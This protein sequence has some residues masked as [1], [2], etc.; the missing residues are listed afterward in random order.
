M[1]RIPCFLLGSFL[2]IQAQQEPP[3]AGIVEE[4]L[5][6]DPGNDLFIRGKNIYDAAQKVDDAETRRGEYLRAVGIF[7]DY[8][9]EF[10]R[11]ANAEA[12]WWYLGSSYNQVGM[13]DDARR[14]F[15]TLLNGFGEGKYA[16]VAAYSMALDHYNQREY[17]FAAPLFEKFAANGSR[18]EDKPTGRLMAGNC[19]RLEGRER[20]A[21]KAFQEV[22]D[23][24]K[25]A[26]L[27]D[28][29]RLYLGHVSFKQGKI[30]EALKLFEQVAKSEAPEKVRAE[31]ALHAAISATK[32]GK[33]EVAETY[34]RIV[35]EK[36]GMETARPD[37]QIA[38]MENYYTAKKYKEVLDVYKKSTVKAEGPKEAARLMIAARAMLQLK[39][40]SEASKLFR[41]IERAVPPEHDLA[42]QAS[43]YRLN[44]FF[45][46]KGEYVTEQ[47][48][49]FLQIYE[50]KRPNDTRIH[51]ALLIKAETLFSQNKIPAAA[52]IYAKIDPKLLSE[53]N[54]AGFLYQRG[55]C[56]AEAGDK[57]GSIQ[58]LSEFITQYPKDERVHHA[59]VKRAKSYVEI[60]EGGK[61]MA[62]YDL[63]TAAKT[64]PADLVSLAWLESARARR[65]EGNIENMLV[66]YKGLLE[67]KD[68]SENLRSEANYWIG[69]GMVK[70]NQPKDAVPFL[71]EARKLRKDAYGKHA[72]LLLALSH[73]AS[74][75]PIQLAAEIELA[76]EGNYASE[77]PA[78]ALQWTGMQSYNAKNYT[79]AAKFLSLTANDKEPRTTPKEVWRYLG[80]SRLEI[81]QTK[82]A[83]IAIG[84][85]LE[86]EDQAAWKADGLLDRARGHYQLKQ[87]D[88]AR[89][90]A[91]EG[92]VLNPQGRTS[93]GL[94][95]V[96]GDLHAQKEN[97]G[98]AAADYLYVI[99]FSQDADLKPLAIHKYILLLEKQNKE[100]EAEKYKTQLKTEFPDWKAP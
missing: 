96:S 45:Q 47:V 63:V 73:F 82:E 43:Y 91:D 100:D 85:V 46:I 74:Q 33:S 22:I 83:L 17:A 79:S 97:I 19:Y 7:N 26:A 51:T 8:L 28:Q 2:I 34:L 58:S 42:F 14:C 67:V 15:S 64:A 77:I 69:W 52:E 50:K 41:E 56:L 37:A 94:R 90:A 44:C 12:A 10:G 29:A 95:I 39:E 53:S 59:L 11:H 92:L 78:Q 84:H 98:A 13:N 20:D 89:K 9:N 48:D 16:G 70:T 88:E 57:Q 76:I 35:L 87:F 60:G 40:V 65:K 32:L 62:D 36:P 27:H 1:L 66:R 93:A 30:D 86:V 71:K 99:Q 80:K 4:A 49:A 6:V 23:D 38:L 81:N 54:R 61:A 21:I 68:L 3:R 25:G 18:P 24:P 55:W 5:Q 31:A 72:G 75:D